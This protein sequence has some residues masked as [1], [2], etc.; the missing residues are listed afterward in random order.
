[1]PGP[2]F[3]FTC[4]FLSNHMGIIT[5]ALTGFMYNGT[6]LGL[7][8]APWKRNVREIYG[9]NAAGT[10]YEVFKPSNLFNSLTQLVQDGVYILDA[11]TPGF[12]LPGAMLSVVP[13]TATPPAPVIPWHIAWMNTKPVY[14]GFAVAIQVDAT[15]AATNHLLMSIDKVAMDSQ[16]IY[17]N[18]AMD[19]GVYPLLAATTYTLRLVDARGNMRL[20]PFDTPAG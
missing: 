10:G 4:Y 18:S 6:T 14:G 9:I 3:L 12:N 15:D 20:T 1:M 11:L 13:A 19:L 8:A 7:A 16:L 17:A 2:A 5:K